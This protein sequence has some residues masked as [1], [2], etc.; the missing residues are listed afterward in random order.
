MFLEIVN[1]YGMEILGAVLTALAGILGMVLTKLGTKYVNTR[2]KREIARTV[3]RGVEQLYQGLNGP[4]KLAKALE[5]GADMLRQAGITVTELE[6]RM[7]LEDAL[8]EFNRV[9]DSQTILEGIDV[10]DLDDDQLRSLL[11]QM[12][13]AYT[14]GMTREEMLAA[15]GEYA[16]V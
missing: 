12:G 4:E 2:V 8:G 7:L 14:D 10:D 3:V 1:T 16:L 13:Y 9:F 6:L 5:A 11:Q 15:L